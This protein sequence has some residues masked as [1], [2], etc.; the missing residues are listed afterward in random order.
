MMLALSLDAHG[1]RS[2]V[3][4]TEPTTA[5][6]PRAAPR[7]RA[8]WSITAASA[9]APRSARSACRRI[10]RPMS[11]ISPA[12]AAGSWRGISMPSEAEKQARGRRVA[13]DRP[14]ARAAPAL[15]PDVCRNIP[16]RPRRTTV[17]AIDL[18]YGWRVRRRCGRDATASRRHRRARRRRRARGMALRAISS[19]ATAA[20]ASCGASSASAMTASTRW[21]RTSRRPHGR[22]PYARAGV[23]AGF[24][25]RG[26]A[27]GNTSG[28]QPDGPQQARLARRQGR[29]FLFTRAPD[30]DGAPDD[31]AIARH[32]RARVGAR[33]RRRFPRPLALDRRAGLGRRALRRGPRRARRRRRA[34]FHADRRLRHEYR[35]RRRR[36][37]RVEAR[38]AGAGLGRPEARWPATRP[39]G[40]RSRSATPSAARGLAHQGRQVPV[41]A[42]DRR[43]LARRRRRARAP[44]RIPLDRVRRGV[45]LARRAAR[46]ALR[47]LADHRRR[48][49]SRRPTIPSTYR[50]SSV[51][52]RPRAASLARQR[53]RPRR[54]L[55]DR[56]GRGFTLLRLRRRRHA[57]PRGGGAAAR[58]AVGDAARSRRTRRASFTS[59]TSPS[60][61]R[62]S[63]LPGAA[64]RFP[65]TAA[66]CWRA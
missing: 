4:N 16:V 42:G 59:A 52:R 38:R 61:A 6:T 60:S 64:T 49:R 37:S 45:R 21:S 36:Q 8:P 43:R 58:R 29:V 33:R 57:R 24:H 5:G 66:S 32:V 20:R 47:R 39:S 26:A 46:R 14:G 56:L 31:A 12:S 10:T 11:A 54:S 15:Q 48:R 1:V 63:M 44:R 40:G 22:D 27:P 2:V 35:R 51:P 9:I 19:A 34:S 7:M 23:L 30:P 18:R 25:R 41:D 17:P 3:V 50:P 65:A 62:T 28:D 53:P 13:A 55:F